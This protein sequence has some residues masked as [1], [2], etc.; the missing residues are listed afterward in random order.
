MR[1]ILFRMLTVLTLLLLSVCASG[2]LRQNVILVPPGEPVQLAE[3]V[4]VRVI[5]TVD[6]KRIMSDNRVVIHAG[7]WALPDPKE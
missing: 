5:V 1:P 2:C 3:D 4:T 6:G 7:W